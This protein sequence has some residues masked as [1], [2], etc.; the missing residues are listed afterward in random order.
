MRRGHQVTVYCRQRPDAPTYLGVDLV[1]LPTIRHKYFDT[2]AHTAVSTLHL[3]AHRTDVAL[4]C[5]AA[6]AIFCFLPRLVGV[7]V[8]LNV[9]GLE[10]KRKKWNRLAR[11]WYL[12]S[13]WLSTFLPTHAVSDAEQIA[14]YYRQRYGAATTFI[15][16]GA[17]TGKVPTKGALERLALQPDHYFLYVTRFEPENNPLLVREA[18]ET[19]DTTVRLALIGDA[20]YAHDYIRRV[21]D[22]RDPRVVI[23]GAIYGAGY[24]E[25][26]SHCLAYVHATEVGG[27]HPALIEAMGRGCL[28]LYLN[29]P[30]NHEVAG[31]AAIPFEADGLAAAMQRVL[32]MPRAERAAWG[33]KAMARVIERYSWDAVTTAYE[34]LFQRYVR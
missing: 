3:V 8:L 22:T 25:L 9:D 15:P 34:N 10:R 32:D 16:Y 12:L 19:L 6:N 28:V 31:D 1:Y 14:A 33:A 17:P 4:Y 30:E 23:P 27:T 29:T 2:I 13:E 24:Q 11:G 5:N 7:P 21:R 26:Q 18:F 20:P